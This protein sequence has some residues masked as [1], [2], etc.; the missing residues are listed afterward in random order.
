M[1]TKIAGILRRYSIFLVLIAL[2][3]VGHLLH[4][5]FF[6]VANMTNVTMQLTVPA[7]LAFGATILIIGGMLDLSAGSVLA[8]AGVLAAQ[9]YVDTDSLVLTMIVGILVGIACNVINALMVATLKAPPF[10]ATLSMMAMA[11]GAALQYTEGRN[12]VMAHDSR[13]SEFGQGSFE[14]PW[15]GGESLITVPYLIVFLILIFVIT[16]YVLRHT[17]LGRSVYA[18]GGNEEAAKASGINV[19]RSK[20][21]MFLINGA[22]VGLAGVLF[23]SRMN[24]GQPNGAEGYE[25]QALTAAVIGGTS[26][27]G[28]VGT[29]SG[30]MVGAFIVRILDN[31]MNLVGVGSHI[32]RMVRG[33]IIALAVIYDI[34]MKNRKT[35]SV[36]GNIEVKDVAHSKEASA[37]DIDKG[38]DGQA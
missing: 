8:L 18:I 6:T 2:I 11:R 20:Y 32:Q 22:F 28:G 35:R 14:L 37:S 13:F 1:Q 29:A 36:M 34:W 7:I 31:I 24:I 15:F 10:I 33:A 12:V 17:R 38:G 3:F 23:M 21:L 5:N 9:V 27:S 19:V 4:H 16:W 26:F 25:F 30:T